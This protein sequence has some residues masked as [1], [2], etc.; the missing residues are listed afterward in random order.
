MKCFQHQEAM[1]LTKASHVKYKYIF[2]LSLHQKLIMED[3]I[4]NKRGKDH[5]TAIL[6]D[7]LNAD[8][9]LIVSPYCYSDFTKFFKDIASNNLLKSISFIT[10]LKD[11][12]AITKVPALQSFLS[13]T[14]EYSIDAKISIMENLHAKIYLFYKDER[15]IS[16]IITSA[17]ITENGLS[18]NYECGYRTNDVHIINNVEQDLQS[19]AIVELTSE[20][21]DAILHRIDEYKAKNK[22]ETIHQNTPSIYIDDLLSIDYAKNKIFLKPIGCNERKIYSGDYSTIEEQRFSK[23]KPRAVRPGDILIVYAVGSAKIV[24]VNKVISEAYYKDVDDRWPWHVQ[25]RN[26]TPALGKIW[27]TRN[28][29]PTKLANEYVNSTGGL[30]VTYVGGKNLKSLNYGLDKLRLTTDFGKFLLNKVFEE[31]IRA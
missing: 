10:T 25:V 6:N 7:A 3:I 24:S 18:R 22:I 2:Y 1:I 12:E 20:K 23:R 9:I 26:L 28:L 11:D 14:D 19:M 27:Y 17:N 8:K 5:Y 29:F 31:N 21:L 15:P 30:P 16:V 4:F 13:A